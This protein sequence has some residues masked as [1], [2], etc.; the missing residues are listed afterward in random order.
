MNFF[1]VILSLDPKD[2]ISRCLMKEETAPENQNAFS[3][4]FIY[5]LSPFAIK[6]KGVLKREK[7]N[8]KIIESKL[9]KIK[10]TIGF[11]FIF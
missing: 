2:V 7:S 11:S 3:Q 9:N 8:I 10:I 1:R 5:F 6:T 4:V